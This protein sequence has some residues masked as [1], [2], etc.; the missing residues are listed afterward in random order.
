M[1]TTEIEPNRT[2]TALQRIKNIGNYPI[3]I[4]HLYKGMGLGLSWMGNLSLLAEA[5]KW[6]AA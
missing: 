2:A 3:N 1:K 6:F 4:W 5:V